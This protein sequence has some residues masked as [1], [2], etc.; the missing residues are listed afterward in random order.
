MEFL[1]YKKIKLLKDLIK[2][3][4][5]LFYFWAQKIKIGLS[6]DKVFAIQFKVKL[7]NG[8]FRSISKIQK[9]DSNDLDLL[10][11]ISISYWEIKSDEYHSSECLKIIFNYNLLNK[12]NLLNKLINQMY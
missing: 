1:S 8:V 6:E 2:I 12:I 4:L 5:H 10:T 7:S 3:S 11:E 9:I